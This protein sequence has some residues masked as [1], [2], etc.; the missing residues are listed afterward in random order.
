MFQ[1]PDL[2]LIWRESTMT[3]KGLFAFFGE[4]LLSAVCA[5]AADTQ[6]ALNLGIA[7]AA[8]LVQSQR[9]KLEFTGV[10]SICRFIFI[11]RER[12]CM[13]FSLIHVSIFSV[14]L[15]KWLSRS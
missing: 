2:F 7:F 5:A 13:R 10:S 4:R 15:P 6:I 1:L 8:C 14:L 9:F 11:L 12:Y 3:R